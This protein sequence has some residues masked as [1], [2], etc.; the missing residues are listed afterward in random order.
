LL[1][2]I[3]RDVIEGVADDVPADV[4]ILTTTRSS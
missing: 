4:V 2:A 3:G 1:R